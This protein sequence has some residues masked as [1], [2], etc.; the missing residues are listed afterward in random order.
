MSV[1]KCTVWFVILYLYVC[2]C[3]AE[4]SWTVDI[5][6]TVKALVGSCVVIPCTFDYPPPNEEVIQ[7]TGIW[8]D[9]SSHVIY[10]P[11]E[12]KALVQYRNRT[13]LL[14]DLRH[15]DCS[16][17]IYPVQK[18]D[19]GSYHFRIEIAEYN[20]YSYREKAVSIITSKVPEPVVLSVKEEVLLADSVSALCS[21][22]H[23]CP[24]SPPHFT[25]THTGQVQVQHQEIGD[26]LW[27]TT[28]TLT[29]QPKPSDNNKPLQCIVTHGGGMQQ[30][31]GTVLSV[32]YAPEIRN[33]SSCYYEGHRVRCMCIAE[34]NPPC[35]V[36][37]LLSDRVLPNI[38]TEQY[39]LLTVV[40]VQTDMGFFSSVKCTANNTLGNTELLLSLPHSNIYI[41]IGVGTGAAVLILIILLI[42]VARKCSQKRHDTESKLHKHNHDTGLRT[43]HYTAPQRKELADVDYSGSYCSDHTYGNAESFD[44]D[45]DDA[46]YANI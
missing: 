12:R 33:A 28:S 42:V 16:L 40:T 41:Y 25:W 46:T 29:F 37:L 35:D 31:A 17:K 13:K 14:G 1:S 10:H 7:F 18:K 9:E 27:R 8:I 43:A 15:K 5:P 3:V 23:T 38:R 45:D 20:N 36:L 26:A 24:D 2:Q 30:S 19:K 39:G 6:S 32:K 34:S 22:S 21:V 11:E 4:S 44:P